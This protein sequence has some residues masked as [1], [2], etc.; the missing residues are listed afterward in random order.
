M[1][2]LGKREIR[3]NTGKLFIYVSI[4]QEGTDGEIL[5]NCGNM[6]QLGKRG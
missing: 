5:N 3:G 6:F 2:Q 1:F 4:G